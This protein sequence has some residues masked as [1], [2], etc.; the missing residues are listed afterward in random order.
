MTR[1]SV[2]LRSYFDAWKRNAKR[3]AIVV[4][5]EEEFGPRNLEAWKYRW[6]Y[7]ILK[8]LV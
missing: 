5:N 2:K 7:I 1:L 8:Q 6:V 3:N 4:Y